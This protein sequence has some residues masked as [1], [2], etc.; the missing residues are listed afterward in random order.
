M[1][2]Q[3]DK[4]ASPGPLDTADRLTRIE[5]VLTEVLRELRARKRRA[6]KRTKS[7]AERAA[8]AAASDTKY[9]PTELDKAAARRALR[10][11]R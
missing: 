11:Y 4:L 6:G 8:M 9:A 5:G 2:D 10:R 7:V 3:H 1:A